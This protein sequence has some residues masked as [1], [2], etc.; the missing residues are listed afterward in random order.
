VFIGTRTSRHSLR[1]QRL[2][3]K[4]VELLRQ[5]SVQDLGDDGDQAIST[6]AASNLI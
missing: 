1:N 2:T 3:S 5:I 4:D 6:A